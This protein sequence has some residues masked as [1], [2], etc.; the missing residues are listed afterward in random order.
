MTNWELFFGRFHP[1][2]VHLPIGIFILGY[3]FEI[4]RNWSNN[5]LAISRKI[6][7]ITYV[8]GLLAGIFAAITGLLLATSN[9]YNY[10]ALNDHKI[11]GIVTLLM[12]ILVIIHQVWKPEHSSR[13][14]LIGSTIAIL[15]TGLTGHFGGNLTH[16]SD[17]LLQ[18][19][20]QMFR[21]SAVSIY[22]K[23]AEMNPDEILIYRDILNPLIQ[24]KCKG[25]HDAKERMGGLNLE[26]F[27]NLFK[28]AN[29]EFP[30]VAGNPDKS[31]VYKR[32]SLP[33]DHEKIMPPKGKGFGYTDLQILRYWI[34][35]GADSL[36]TFDSNTMS[37]DLIALIKRDYQ[38]DF[39]PRPYYEKVK[40]DS[41]EEGQLTMLRS[42]GFR[43][44]YLGVNNHLL[45]IAYEKDTIQI[46]QIK[47]LNQVANSITFLKLSN[48]MLSDNLIESMAEM[49][50]LTKID[51]SKNPLS[52]AL[53]K[54]L[55]DHPNLETVNLNE[56]LLTNQGLGQLISKL[57]IIRVYALKT[58]VSK[59]SLDSL[60]KI[61]TGTEIIAEEFKFEK[62]EPA[63]SVFEKNETKD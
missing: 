23:V 57:D 1:L 10:E 43:V 20:P 50:H 37:E 46:G 22:E 63:K 62:I 28:E 55:L 24:E 18:Y 45:D 27:E 29:R 6:V 42:A 32:L 12:M 58:S 9:D 15:L 25:C 21:N 54:H 8:I 11:L 26:A 48:C 41:L 49:P 13:L 59:S 53:V 7:V 56:T 51:L 33:L 30:I 3:I 40:I 35:S 52:E 17:Y 47:L 4:I 61:N 38:L 44:N 31:E 14:K 39:S 19:G 60:R 36:G 16:G 34:E 5:K 2:I